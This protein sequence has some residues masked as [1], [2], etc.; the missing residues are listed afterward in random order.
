MIYYK[1]NNNTLQTFKN[2][3]DHDLLKYYNTDDIRNYAISIIYGNGLNEVEQILRTSNLSLHYKALSLLYKKSKYLKKYI[4]SRDI[5]ILHYSFDEKMS[6]SSNAILYH[7]NPE[8]T[9]NADIG[10]DLF[11]PAILDDNIRQF[12]RKSEPY[13]MMFPYMEIFQYNKEKDEIIE[14]CECGHEEFE[15]TLKSLIK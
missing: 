5:D 6:K 8:G 3:E 15:K 7:E 11:L 9:E 10:A 13:L 1:A 2:K 14:L 12:L 4:K